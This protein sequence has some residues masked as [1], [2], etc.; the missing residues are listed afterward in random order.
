VGVHIV[1]L[2]STGSRNPFVGDPDVEVVSFHRLYVLKDL[3]GI[4]IIIVL[5]LLVCLRYPDLFSDPVNFVP[6]DPLKTPTHIQPE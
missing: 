4:V 3:V 1:F 6:A 2:H 5:I